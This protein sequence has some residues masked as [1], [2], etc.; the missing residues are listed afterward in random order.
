MLKKIL[1]TAIL[2]FSIVCILSNSVIAHAGGVDKVERC[3]NCRLPTQTVYMSHDYLKKAVENENQAKKDF[4]S[5]FGFTKYIPVIG[6]ICGFIID[7]TDIINQHTKSTL[8][9]MLEASK[10]KGKCGAVAR[11]VYIEHD[12]TPDEWIVDDWWTQC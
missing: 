4:K 10:N 8:Q 7:V 5:I 11:Y 9:S 1:Q 2:I 3:S 6:Q 12:E